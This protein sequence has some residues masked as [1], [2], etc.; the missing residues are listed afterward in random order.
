VAANGL[1]REKAN[2]FAYQD[3]QELRDAINP[4]VQEVLKETTSIASGID[5]FL[6]WISGG[7]WGLAKGGIV[8]RGY[9]RMPDGTLMANSMHKKGKRI[10][11]MK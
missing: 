9:H 1:N 5:K 2:D 10:G 4:Q 6:S 3:T 7:A 11:D 8:P